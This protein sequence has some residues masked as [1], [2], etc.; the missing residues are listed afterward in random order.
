MSILATCSEQARMITSRLAAVVMASLLANC[1]SAPTFSRTVYENPTILVRLDS[2]VVQ[3][4]VSGEPRGEIAELTPRNL[5]K[6]LQ[7]VRIQP[8]ISFLSY[9]VLRQEP[10]PET[11]FP[12][13]EAQLLAPHLRAAL[14]KARP[15]ETAVFFLRRILEDGIPLVTSGLVK[16]NAKMIKT[17]ELMRT[18]DHRP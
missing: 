4:E 9:W 18:K 14:A 16:L 6:L 5:A 2:P 1:A 12:K 3:E 8:E 17:K 13:D 11:A 7:S 10:Q 15:N